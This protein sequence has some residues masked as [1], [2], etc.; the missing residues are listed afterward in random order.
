MFNSQL[1]HKALANGDDTLLLSRSS[2]RWGLILT[3]DTTSVVYLAAKPMTA[4]KTGLPIR[5]DSSPIYLNVR[6]HGDIVQAE[7]HA[8]ATSGGATL[9]IVEIMACSCEDQALLKDALGHVAGD[10]EWHGANM[11]RK[12]GT[13]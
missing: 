13:R 10:K 4:V 3:L 2:T 5:A 1:S 9:G 6:D 8:W 7:W 12:G 11:R